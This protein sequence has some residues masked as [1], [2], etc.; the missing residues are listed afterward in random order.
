MD[1][2][3]FERGVREAQWDIARDTCR[4]FLRARSFWGRIADNLRDGYRIEVVYPSEDTWDWS[5]EDGYNN[6]VVAH[7][8]ES[9][10]PG[11]WDRIWEET[12]EENESHGLSVYSG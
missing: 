11:T 6:T 4:M 2:A 10:G 8:D 12:W 7:L 1:Q 9:Y 3:A 5:F